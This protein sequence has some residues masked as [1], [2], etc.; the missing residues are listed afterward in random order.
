[1][2]DSIDYFYSPY[3]EIY[4]TIEGSGLLGLYSVVVR[5]PEAPHCG[6]LGYWHHGTS[7]QLH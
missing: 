3:A 1:M 4:Q 7:D 5:N 2:S 6:Y